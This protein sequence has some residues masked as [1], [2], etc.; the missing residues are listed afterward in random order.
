M[1]KENNINNYSLGNYT[2][3]NIISCRLLKWIV[4]K[5]SNMSNN[6]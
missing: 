6:K 2:C 4:N 3:C 1:N 5:G